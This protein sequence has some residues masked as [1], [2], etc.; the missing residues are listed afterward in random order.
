MGRKHKWLSCLLSAGLLLG[1]LTTGHAAGSQKLKDLTFSSPEQLASPCG[2]TQ[3]LG[4]SFGVN[5]KGEQIFYGVCQGNPA[6]VIAYNVD[7]AT[8]ED[9]KPL[10]GPDTVGKAAYAAD[11]GPDGRVYIAAHQFFFIYDPATKKVTS[12]PS[13]FS[14]GSV[15]NRGTFDQE[16]NYYFGTYPNASLVQFN[17]EKNALVN[18]GDNMVRGQYVRAVA[19]YG[20]KI[21]MGSMGTPD[22]AQI[23]R[24]DVN[25]KETKDIPLPEYNGYPG[26]ECTT[27]YTIS[28]LGG[29]YMAAKLMY[30]SAGT[31]VQCVMD[32]ETETWIDSFT[33]ANHTHLSELDGDVFYYA[34]QKN[35]CSR[36]ILT[37][38]TKT[39]D[40]IEL[41]G[42]TT[43]L[44]PKIVTLKD[45][46]KYPGKSLIANSQS[47]GVMVVNFE[48]GSCE[49]FSDGFPVQAAGMR[50]IQAGYNGDIVCSA[51]QG[52][53]IYVY[54]MFDN[55]TRKA[56]AAQMESI[57]R[58]DGKYYLG[59]YGSGGG[60]YE[61]DPAKPAEKGVNP[62]LVSTLKAAK[63]KQDRIFA[64]VDGGD[65]IYYGSVP[66]YGYFGGCIAAY[67]KT[68]KETKIFENIVKDHSIVGLTYKDGKLYGSTTIFGGLGITPQEGTARV[69]IFDPQTG[70]VEVEKTLKLKKDLSNQLFAGNI[71]FSPDGR[72]FVGTNNVLVELDPVDV[73]VKNEVVIGSQPDMTVADTRWQGFFFEWAPNGLLFTNIGGKVSAVDIDTMDFKVLD[74]NR[75]NAISLGMD[76]NLYILSNGTASVSRITLGGLSPDRIDVIRNNALM[77]KLGS[78]KALYFGVEKQI[79]PANEEVKAL[80]IDGRTLVPV[81]FLAE[82]YGALVDWNEETQTVT[83]TIGEKIVSITLGEQKIKVMDE[84]IAIDVPAQTIQDRTM[85]PL[86]AFVENVMGRTVYFDD[87]NQLIVIS[88]DTL[89]DGE[90][91][92]SILTEIG[93]L[94]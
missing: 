75:S 66:Y 76:N 51:M 20:D 72:L 73:S 31:Y 6:Q 1:T 94:F 93:K 36:N 86:R 46:E 68:T 41:S 77:L 38:E 24:Y 4:G 21:F 60:I 63:V 44:T 50:T 69:F 19:S 67:D 85:L 18:L 25:T 58:T 88:N 55:T 34:S 13:P 5:E 14:E 84:E 83:L 42:S 91:D 62:A 37:K 56:P 28:H 30:P 23:V 61:F 39:Y 7:T 87:S 80:E 64:S 57:L 10:Q 54:N 43:M 16:G 81:R 71:S 9:I 74:G 3:T 48:K 12:Y 17:L 33:G 27:V 29:K 92:A 79:D 70:K 32:M 22:Q 2:Y 89:I 59:S 8:A 15:M 52:S 26:T 47:E 53:A 82:N 11:V 90:K 78:S 35:I 49:Y 65:K 40:N 45:Q